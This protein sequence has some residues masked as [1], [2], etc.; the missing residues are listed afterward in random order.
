[1]SDDLAYWIGFSKVSG[2]GPAR[3]RK[4]LDYFGHIEAAWHAS[5]DELSAMGLDKRSIASLEQAQQT[6]DLEEELRR[7]EAASVRVLTWDDEDYPTPLRNIPD[8]PFVLYI[9]GTL[10]DRDEWALAVVGTRGAS[11][12]G[13]EVTRSMVNG[14]AA[15]GVTIVSGMALGIDTQ[16]HQSALEVG[17]RTIAVLGCGVDIVYPSQNA[18]LARSIMENGALVSEYPLGSKPEGRNFPPRNRIISGLSLGVLIVEGSEH[19]GALITTNYALEQGREV[20]AVPGNIFNRTSKGPNR[21]IQQGAKLIT[22]VGDILEELNLTMVAQHTEAREVI[23]DTLM[24]AAI[25]QYLSAEPVHID[26]LGAHTGIPA[27]ELASTLTMME[28][29]GQ[30]RQVGGMNYVIAREANVRYVIE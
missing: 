24:E 5:S 16:A 23:P 22:S 6:L 8:P 3:L 25:L 19:S 29:K 1:M 9:R 4:L 17:G 10:L 30:V 13:K 12:Y 18:K 2:V 7:I 21:L 14:L 28:L 26:E 27:A 15:S 11:I 20:F